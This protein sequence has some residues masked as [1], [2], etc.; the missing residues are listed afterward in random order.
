MELSFFYE[1]F[2]KRS[3]LFNQA[4]A[5]DEEEKIFCSKLV[6]LLQLQNGQKFFLRG[7]V[8]GHCLNPEPKI[9]ARALGVAQW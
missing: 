1:M 2:P 4:K 5:N 8:L 7:G 6:Q 3:I 9:I